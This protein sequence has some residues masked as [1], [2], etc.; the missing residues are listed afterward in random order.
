MW[1][2]GDLDRRA[3]SADPVATVGKAKDELGWRKLGDLDPANHLVLMATN[4]AR[5]PVGRVLVDQRL[6]QGVWNRIFHDQ[7][8]QGT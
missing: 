8:P 2:V 6:E 1:A 7:P 5:G 4:G 3:P